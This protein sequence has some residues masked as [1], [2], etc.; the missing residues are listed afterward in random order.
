MLPKEAVRPLYRRAR[1]EAR[2]S[3]DGLAGSVHDPLD[4]LVRYCEGLLPL[5]PFEVWSDDLERFPDAHLADL[6]H[7]AVGPTADEPATLDERT[8]EYCG[9]AWKASLRTYREAD[10]WRAFI[11]FEGPSTAGPH[12]T[13]PVFCE[14]DVWGL[15]E[16]FGSFEPAALGAF[17]RSALP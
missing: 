14:R 7:S 5:P 10:L 4:L 2:S 8:F 15:L 11:A 12:Q 6:E 13:A 1:L 9:A 16:R 3:G 17:L